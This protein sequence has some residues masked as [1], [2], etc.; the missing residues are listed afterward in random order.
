MSKEVKADINNSI[1]NKIYSIRGKQVIL[2]SD[3]A[4]L[5]EVKT[6]QLNRAVKRN[7]ER[8]PENFMFQLTTEEYQNLRSQNATLETKDSLRFQNGTL[9][10]Q[11]DLKFQNGTSN[12]S[13]RSQIVT[14]K[15]SKGKHR[16][17]LPFVFTEQGVSMLA[18]IL[19]S[20]KAIKISIQIINAF[21]TMRRFI[22][23]NAQI[24]QRLDTIEIKQIKYD[25][26]IEQIFKEIE[27]KEIKPKQGIFFDGQVFDAL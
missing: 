16:K 15:R 23:K 5:Y 24:F 14:I 4:E 22:S 19:R 2:D 3:L 21:V 17:Y 26:R 10:K 20:K 27:N 6:K 1:K 9:E 25:K 12:S 13:I 11:T 18:G 7:I 8:F